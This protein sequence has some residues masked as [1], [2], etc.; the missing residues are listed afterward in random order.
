MRE[1][2]KALKVYYTQDTFGA[3]DL[4][5]PF[6]GAVRWLIAVSLFANTLAMS[7]FFALALA[8][9]GRLEIGFGAE[10]A[11]GA[12]IMSSLFVFLILFMN[13]RA[14]MVEK[15]TRRI[16]E[17]M[18]EKTIGRMLKIPFKKG[19]NIEG[20][21][22]AVL[23]DL[24]QA[25]GFLANSHI[26]AL[27]DFPFIVV[28][29]GGLGVLFSNTIVIPAAIAII[30]IIFL[31]VAAGML[32]SAAEGYLA[33]KLERDEIAHMSIRDI[34]SI[35]N[36]NLSQKITN[37]FKDYQGVMAWEEG[38]RNRV[39]DRMMLLSGAIGFF[40]LLL[41]GVAGGAMVAGGGMS[42]GA[43][44]AAVMVVL[45]IHII[46]TGFLKYL[47]EHYRFS[48]SLIRLSELLA[49]SAGE[50][51]SVRIEEITDGDLQ[52]SDVEIQDNQGS[53]ILK[54]ASYTFTEGMPFVI[55]AKSSFDAGAFLKLLFGGYKLSAGRVKFDKYDV[56]SLS[57][58][59]MK[60]YIRFCPENYFVIDGT[61]K[62]NLTCFVSKG[63]TD[64]D[65]A[66]FMGYREVAR[67]LGLD[68]MVA[69]LP[70]GYNTMLSSTN[71]V[72]NEEW[73][74]LLSVARTFVG[75]PRVLLFEQP[76][77]GLSKSAASAFLELVR[78]VSLERI[79]VISSSEGIYMPRVVVDITGGEI[80]AGLNETED[81]SGASRSTFRRA[82]GVK[83][84]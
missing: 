76:M 27:L 41:V 35:K 39:L 65:F 63:A 58:D 17:K 67:L 33:A 84:T 8:I 47:P 64:E 62:D 48:N 73:L 60:D 37:M 6:R 61:V 52:L 23:A 14:G 16:D 75:N 59:S 2:S 1:H 70:N 78:R 32:G 54:G 9:D 26:S 74:K 44:A 19:S 42:V 53:V 81:E 11:V 40:T 5:L 69:K 82:F 25:R 29:A 83:K 4:L 71:N 45:Y 24:D 50:Q 46:A 43:L 80:R 13:I 7:L 10:G 79:V 12:A 55:A 15:I 72:L 30:Y 36:L 31:S 3:L 18:C 28:F 34:S 68:E 38:K 77:Q 57:A 21:M 22:S 20:L 56:A 49:Q 66:G 51:K